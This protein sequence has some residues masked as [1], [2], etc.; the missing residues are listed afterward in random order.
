M[1]ESGDALIALRDGLDDVIGQQDAHVYGV[2]PH[3]IVV[4]AAEHDV[5]I[6]DSAAVRKLQ[7]V[8]AVDPDRIGADE[9]QLSVDAQPALLEQL[10][11]GGILGKLVRVGSTARKKPLARQCPAS[12]LEEQDLIVSLR[13]DDCGKHVSSRP[14]VIRTNT[15]N[16]VAH[17]RNV[18]DLIGALRARI[19]CL[20][21]GVPTLRQMLVT[22]LERPCAGLG[23]YARSLHT[24]ETVLRDR[25]EEKHAKRDND[26]DRHGCQDQKSLCQPLLPRAGF[27]PSD[28]RRRSPAQ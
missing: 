1:H 17:A 26:D 6:S 23:S 19:G 7:T 12:P 11:L 15:K 9:F 13:V 24:S 8:A 14:E 10:P 25:G 28:Q 21:G 5:T 3:L 2:Y 4:F 16:V 20:L 27:G 22:V 18:R